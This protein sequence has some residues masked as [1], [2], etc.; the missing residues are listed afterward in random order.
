MQ[1]TLLPQAE[2][3]T[4][5]TCSFSRLIS[6]ILKPTKAIRT[7]TFSPMSYPSAINWLKRVLCYGAVSASYTAA[8]EWSRHL[9][10]YEATSL[11][12][13]S[14]PDR[15]SLS[16]HINRN[17][18]STWKRSGSA[19]LYRLSWSILSK[20]YF[21]QKSFSCQCLLLLDSQIC[22]RYLQPQLSYYKW[23]IFCT[24]VLILSPGEV[25]SEI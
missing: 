6:H 25:K 19:V 18:I 17:N 5:Q 22:W 21:I 12:I 24:T 14:P 11:R 23:K 15:L 3:W 1:K 9:T 7:P 2:L 13:L 8:T 10:Q 4:R 16:L 20:S